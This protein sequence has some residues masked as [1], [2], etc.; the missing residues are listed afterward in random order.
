MSVITEFTIPAEAFALEHTF[1]TVSDVTIQIERLASHSREWVMP[2]CW[3]TCEDLEAVTDALREDPTVDGVRLVD[4]DSD[5]GYLNVHWNESVQSLIDTVVDQHG[6]M[7]EVEANDGIWHL[8][9]KFLDGDAVQKF[10]T[11]FDE[12]GYSF[13]LQRLYDGTAPKER[14]YDLTADQREALVMALEMG[15]FDVP[16]EA[17]IED[18]AAELEISTNAVSQRL[19]R[20]NRNL[21]RNT[22]TVSPPTETSETNESE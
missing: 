16:R 6:I 10:Q 15:Y 7:Q 3:V 5:V 20:A 18:L 2:F 9:L 4:S 19:R 14:E 1:D 11:Y 22:L 13:E 21:T 17:N 12:K 8:K